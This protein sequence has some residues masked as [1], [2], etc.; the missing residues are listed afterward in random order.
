MTSARHRTFTVIAWGLLSLTLFV[1][2]HDTV[3]PTTESCV[4]GS[5]LDRDL[6]S[7]REALRS[8]SGASGPAGLSPDQVEGLIASVRRV[9]LPGL[10][11][12]SAAG[13]RAPQ[14]QGEP[15]VEAI[16]WDRLVAKLRDQA[17][18]KT[19]PLPGSS[20]MAISKRE[21][22]QVRALMESGQFDSD[23]RDVVATAIE[24]GFTIAHLDGGA[25]LRSILRQGPRAISREWLC[26]E[27]LWRTGCMWREWPAVAR[28]LLTTGKAG[29]QS[30]YR[31]TLGVLVGTE[32]GAQIFRTVARLLQNETVRLALVLYARSQ[33]VS[34]SD[35]Q[36]REV[37]RFFDAESGQ[38][39]NLA[40][41]LAPALSTLTAQ[42]HGDTVLMALGRLRNRWAGPSC[43]ASI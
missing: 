18:G 36:L 37:A 30:L 4:R 2:C 7:L 9:H 10:L 16:P 8:P 29:D 35:Q 1:G 22:D 41:L 24:A 21:L 20:T 11:I 33:G 6:P 17:E 27:G 43:R 19:V 5:V 40:V 3:A 39:A 32:E 25:L 14:G 15:L 13:T 42:Y 26:L 28:A 34:I 12:L 23:V 38:Q 31:E